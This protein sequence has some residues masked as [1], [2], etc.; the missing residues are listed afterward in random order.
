MKILRFK[1]YFIF[2]ALTLSSIGFAQITPMQYHRDS[3]A[4]RIKDIQA[5]HTPE[6]INELVEVEVNGS[7][8]WLSVRGINKSNPILLVVHGGPGSPLMG[9]T[10]TYQKPWEDFFTVVNWDQRGVGKNFSVNDTSKIKSTMTEEQHIE[11]ALFVVQYLLKKMNHKKMFILGYS[12]GTKFTPAVVNKNP[13]LFYAWIGVGVVSPNSNAEKTIYNTLLELANEKKDKEALRELNEIAPY[14][15]PEKFSM[16]K[17]LIV[18]KWARKYNGGWYGKENF[19]LLFSLHEWSPEY[20]KKEADFVLDAT[21]WASPLIIRS[22]S[23]RP[24]L[25]FRIPVFYLMGKNDLHTP[26]QNAFDHF[27]KIDAPMKKF[28]TFERSAHLPM[29]EEPGKFLLSLVQD[30]LPLSK[31]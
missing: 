6:G 7:K 10:W 8:Q 14:P 27:E 31:Q 2:C 23:N 18:R 22:F 17:T 3:I 19:D 1:L 21:S 12:W 25:R 20:S 9:M 5:I 4:N 13:D 15:D 29:L 24:N 16:K 28:I 26:F 11:D 30:V